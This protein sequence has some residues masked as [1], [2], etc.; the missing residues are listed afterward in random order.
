MRN[1]QYI[2]NLCQNIRT[3]QERKGL[4]TEEMAA[5][6]GI[7]REL[8]SRIENGELPD[9]LTVETLVRLEGKF[10]ISLKDLF[11]PL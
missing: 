1:Q 9:G 11:L 6:L 3:L 8:F 7:S 5:E 10:G 4:S 2:Q